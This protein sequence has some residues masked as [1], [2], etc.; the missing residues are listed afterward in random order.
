MDT[1]DREE[2]AC[3]MGLEPSGNEAFPIIGIQVDEE[4]NWIPTLEP[5]SRP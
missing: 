1:S 3:R 4:R 5:G 2:A